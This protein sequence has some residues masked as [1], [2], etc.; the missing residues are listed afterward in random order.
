MNRLDPTGLSDTCPTCTF[1][2]TTVAYALDSTGSGGDGGD[3]GYAGTGA[4]VGVTGCANRID[5][6]SQDPCPQVHFGGGSDK[7]I[8]GTQMRQ[9]L[10]A[11][12]IVALHALGTNSKCAGL[13]GLTGSAGNTSPIALQVLS[14]LFPAGNVLQFFNFAAIRNNGS[15]VTSAT[16]LGVGSNTV[17][18]GNGATMTVSASVTITLNDTTGGTAFVSGNQNDWAITLLHELG[19]VYWDL[20]GIGTSGIV[21][22]GDSGQQSIDNTKLIEKDCNLQGQLQ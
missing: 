7:F 9:E 6:G 13:F 12:L 22:D 17:S 1:N 8:T 14:N 16:T 2:V 15:Y 11:G 10:G 5:K 20:Y 18:V 3:G 21:P 4:G 19:H